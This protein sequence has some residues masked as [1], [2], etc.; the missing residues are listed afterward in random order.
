MM[1]VRSLSKAWAPSRIRALLAGLFVVL[2]SSPLL[3]GSVGSSGS[4]GGSSGGSV[5]GTSMT[6]VPGDD[7]VGLPAR[8]DSP[9]ITFVG[10]MR[11]LRS[12]DARFQG[13]GRIDVNLLPSGL[14]ALTFVGNYR[15]EVDRA[16]L[17]R[18]HVAVLFRSGSTFT[19]GRA[20]LVLGGSSSAFLTP[21]R[22]PLPLARLA[23]SPSVQGAFLTLDAL[24]PNSEQA[25]V[26]VHFGAERVTLFQRMR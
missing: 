21:Q 16:A 19:D 13:R 18:S 3:A 26:G 10:E 7:V 25:H 24:G 9:G 22:L 11:E 17:A 6:S 20:Q 12:L 1:Q 14:V 23:E 15:I 2:G 5:G 4:S 8:A